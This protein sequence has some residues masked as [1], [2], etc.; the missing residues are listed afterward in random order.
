[1]TALR[2]R[3]EA[4][5][6]DRI[7]DASVDITIRTSD[8]RELKLLVEHAIGSVEKPM[9]DAQLRAKFAGQSEPVLGAAKTGLAW[10]LAMGLAQCPDLRDFIAATT[11]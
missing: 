3:V 9:I 2:A 5:V 6:D 11:H 7:D 4:I 1:M 8:G 10:S